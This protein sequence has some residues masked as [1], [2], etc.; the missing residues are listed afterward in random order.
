VIDFEEMVNERSDR[1]LE[2]GGTDIEG[3]E[4]GSVNLQEA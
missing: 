4:M 2:R 3:R 1:L